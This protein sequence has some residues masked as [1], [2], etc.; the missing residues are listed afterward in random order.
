MDIKTIKDA[1]VVIG[2]SMAIQN[3]ILMK[4]E[5]EFLKYFK[6]NSKVSMDVCNNFKNSSESEHEYFV[7][8]MLNKIKKEFPELLI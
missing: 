5:D 7:E 6:M 8:K 2:V 4:E 3:S 1:S